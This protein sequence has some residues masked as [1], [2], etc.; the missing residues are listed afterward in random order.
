M[1]GL[2]FYCVL[3]LWG[4]YALFVAFRDRL[5]SYVKLVRLVF[6]VWTVSSIF[7]GVIITPIYWLFLGLSLGIGKAVRSRIKYG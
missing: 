2:V 7:A 5:P 4:G 3:F 6:F 1:V